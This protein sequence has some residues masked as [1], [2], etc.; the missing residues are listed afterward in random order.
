MSGKA[1][2]IEIL[3][4]EAQSQVRIFWQNF[5]FLRWN[6]FQRPLEIFLWTLRTCSGYLEG[7]P[8]LALC[9]SKQIVT[10]RHTNQIICQEE[11]KKWSSKWGKNIL[12][13]PRKSVKLFQKRLKSIKISN[14]THP[15][16]E[17]NVLYLISMSWIS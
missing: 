11:W 16:V 4:N 17:K 3:K 9:V 5:I 12:T 2:K 10:V 15:M 13:K 6:F 8:N 1:E 14:S 7:P